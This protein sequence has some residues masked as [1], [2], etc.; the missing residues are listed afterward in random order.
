MEGAELAAE[1]IKAEAELGR[2]RIRNV[3][4][5]TATYDTRNAIAAISESASQLLKPET[6][7]DEAR[8]KALVDEII[9]QARQLDTLAAELPNILDELK[10]L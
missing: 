5:D 7:A 3:I 8:R 2:A 1:H 10:Q 4:L 9:M 6:I